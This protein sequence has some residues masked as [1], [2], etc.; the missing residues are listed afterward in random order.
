MIFF[1]KIIF[2]HF[3]N[4]EADLRLLNNFHNIRRNNTKYCVPFIAC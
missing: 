3:V 1:G 4:V 2:I